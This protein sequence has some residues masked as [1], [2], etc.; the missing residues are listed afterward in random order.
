MSN[1]GILSSAINIKDPKLET[2]LDEA[3]NAIGQNARKPLYR[4]ILRYLN[5]QTYAFPLAVQLAFAATSADLKG[6]ETFHKTNLF[7]FLSK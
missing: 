3:N 2:L 4:A 7:R 6:Y 5:E 1:N